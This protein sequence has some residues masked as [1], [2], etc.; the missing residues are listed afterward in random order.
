MVVPEVQNNV[1]SLLTE[2]ITVVC[3][4]ALSYREEFTVNGL[5]VVNV[6]R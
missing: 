6:D 1:S 5:L 2:A 4:N 3:K